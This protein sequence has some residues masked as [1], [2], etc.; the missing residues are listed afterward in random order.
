MIFEQILSGGDRNYG[1]LAGCEKTKQAVVFDPSPDPSLCFK[2]AKELGLNVIY[3]VDTHTHSDHTG[4]NSFF[5][6]KT[7]AKIVTHRSTYIGEI[8][9]SD[10][11]TLNVGDLTLKF[12]HTPGHTPESI[13]ILVE[14]ELVTGDTLFV[15]KVGGTSSLESAKVEFESLKKLMKLAPET[16]VWPGHNYGVR[17]TSTIKEELES[18]PFILRLNSFEDFMWLK[19]NWAAYK[20]E[21]GIA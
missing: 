15:G 12:I 6:K 14:N 21:H 19:D 9:V 16:R 17:P 4:G 10:G 2:R 11:D 18:N 13:C 20:K 3:I 5:Q 8:K 1:Y 7:D